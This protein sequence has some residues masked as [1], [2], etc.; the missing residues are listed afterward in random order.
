MKKNSR[1]HQF[2]FSLF[3][4]YFFL[5]AIVVILFLIALSIFIN[6]STQTQQEVYVQQTKDIFYENCDSLSEDI[7]ASHSL[8]SATKNLDYY[9]NVF[10][11]STPYT[12]QHFYYFSKM[13]NFFSTQLDL[14]N[15]AED[16]FIYNKNSGLC[17][18]K[19][20]V[21]VELNDAAISYF[22]YEEEY[23]IL[24]ML[25]SAKFQNRF[26]LFPAKKIAI[27]NHAPS[28][29]LAVLIQSAGNQLYGFFYPE[30][31]ILESF[32]LSALPQDTYLKL[33]S[34]TG[35]LLYSYNADGTA[36]TENI[37]FTSTISSLGCTATLGIPQSY[38]D[39]LTSTS[40]ASAHKILILSMAIG[41]ALCILFS[42]FGV[43]P[44]QVLIRKHKLLKKHTKNEAE[45]IDY[46]LQ[47]TQQSNEALRNMLLSSVLIRAFHSV[48]IKKD[49]YDNLPLEFPIFNNPLRLS[50]IQDLDY[51]SESNNS[52]ILT[53]HF[54]QYS[55]DDCIV[56][57]L[58]SSEVCVIM[59]SDQLIPEVQ[60]ALYE[61]N[62][63]FKQKTRFV[64]GISAPFSKPVHISRA[65]RQ[66]KFSLP[67]ENT[68]F[69]GIFEEKT[70]NTLR[71]SFGTFD[72]KRFQQELSAWNEEE[73]RNIFKAYSHSIDERPLEHP[74]EIFYNI[75]YLLRTTAQ[76][77]KMSLGIYENIRY[78]HSVSTTANFNVLS[79]IAE[80]LFRQKKVL[81]T[82]KTQQLC[83]I[84][85][86]YMR[87]NLNDS[88]LSINTLTRTFSVSERFAHKA[89][90]SVTDMSF[91][92]FLLQIRMEEAA[93][94]FRETD[95]SI[96]EISEHCGF[97]VISTFYRNF[98][99]YY[100]KTPAEYKEMYAPKS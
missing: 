66:A 19:R 72:L 30:S 84:L 43:K 7:L 48:P 85:V 44:F 79:D 9:I 32:N 25:E 33:T 92:K 3:W 100:H 6:N 39:S 96:A 52:A 11:P 83:E 75:S 89:I 26:Q 36:F 56:E 73:V 61:I 18:T 34:S 95:K 28:L 62:L 74:E 97:P 50:I 23:S 20:R 99:N 15:L 21:F 54:A 14:L 88:S 55:P 65:M 86:Q 47:T 93:R 38:F 94:L 64:C 69:V 40:R 24:N 29:Y 35:E 91:S 45:T 59:Q 71:S 41:I 1:L 57:P 49:E 53:M 13:R 42:Y 16:G 5:L 2:K 78:Q 81:H 58:S 22:S 60:R 70:E 31:A 12:P 67:L 27:S 8:I 4:R 80:E 87:E 51:P 10:Y 76:D 37:E 77:G 98:K 68:Q 17:I 46:F 82:S 63:D 90:L